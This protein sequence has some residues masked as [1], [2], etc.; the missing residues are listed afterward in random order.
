MPPLSGA[1]INEVITALNSGTFDARD[2][3]HV[4]WTPGFVDE[5]GWEESVDLAAKT[6][7]RVIKI[8]ADSAKRL[9]KA[10]EEGIPATMVLMNFE[11]LP[12]EAKSAKGAKRGKA[13][14]TG[15]EGLVILSQSG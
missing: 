13:K 3:R 12:P 7:D 8:H 6:L 15:Q 2:D 9:A 10:G 1:L 14:K 5:Q 11:G 4:S